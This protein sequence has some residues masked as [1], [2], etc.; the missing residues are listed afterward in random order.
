MPRLISCSLKY[1]IDDMGLDEFKR[2]VE[3]R[4]RRILLPPRDHRPFTKNIDD[5]S[6]WNKGDDG[7]YSHTIFIENGI[8]AS[9]FNLNIQGVL[10]TVQASR[11][12]LVC[13]RLLIYMVR[14]K[15]GHFRL[16]GNQHVIVCGISETQLPQ[17]QESSGKIHSR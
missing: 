7:L 12:N 1:T 9:D 2:Q 13:L 4:L 8:S 5:F 17:H 11:A 3:E 10:K 6:G 16:T 14:S 15:S